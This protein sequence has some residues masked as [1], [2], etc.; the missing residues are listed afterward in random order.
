[1]ANP[2]ITFVDPLKSAEKGLSIFL[3]PKHS[4]PF[5]PPGGK[6]IDGARVF[7][8]KRTSHE[9]TISDCKNECKLNRP[10]PTL[11]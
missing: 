8:A 6:V 5:I 4:L 9:G 3:V 1:M 10:D 7:D 11:L 2:V